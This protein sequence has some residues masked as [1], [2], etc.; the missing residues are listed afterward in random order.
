MYTPKE[1]SFLLQKCLEKYLKN[2]DKNIRILDTKKIPIK[3]FQG[4]RESFRI[5]DMGTGSGIQAETC[6]LLGFKNVLAADTDEEA[7]NFVK[8]KLKIKTLK[9][10]LFENIRGNFDLIIF[11]PP[12]LPENK[13][14]KKRDTSGGKKGDETIIR[15][16]T[17]AKNHLAEDGKILLLLSSLTPRTRINKTLANYNVKKIT[18]ESFFFEKLEVLIISAS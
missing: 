12:Y 14:D 3:N 17:Q 6:L 7:V 18:Q 10:N 13:H 4:A 16:L 11:N 2:K 15:F 5:L 9:T 1:D 8:S